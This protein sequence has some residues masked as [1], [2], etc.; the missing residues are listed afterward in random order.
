MYETDM[1]NETHLVNMRPHVGSETTQLDFSKSLRKT[2]A[3]C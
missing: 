1:R 3:S 2:L